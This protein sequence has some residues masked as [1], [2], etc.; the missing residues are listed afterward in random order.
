MTETEI[1]IYAA[2]TVQDML[3]Q[4]IA[5]AL[6][7]THADNGVAFEEQFMHRLRFGLTIP[8]DADADSAAHAQA[9]QTSALTRAARFFEQVR[10]RIPS[11]G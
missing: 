10:R 5:A 2:L 7:S 1:D 4:Q 8:P 6:L 3:L 9:L 11:G